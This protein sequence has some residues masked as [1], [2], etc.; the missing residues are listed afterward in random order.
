MFNHYLGGE[1]CTH[2]C[3]DLDK[4]KVGS[5]PSQSKMAIIE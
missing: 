1:S 4:E 3:Q 2:D 5:H